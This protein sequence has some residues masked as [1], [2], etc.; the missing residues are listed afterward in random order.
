MAVPRVPNPVKKIAS[1]LSLVLGLCGPAVRAQVASIEAKGSQLA[2]PGQHVGDSDWFARMTSWR[3]DDAAATG[4]WIEAMRA[5]RRA[6]LG[7]MR[8]DGSQYLRPELGWTQRNFVQP[9]VMAEERYLYDPVAG[10]YTVDRLLDDLDRRYGGVDSVLLWPVYPNMGIDNRNQWD[11]ARDMPGGT[12]ALRAMVGDFHR[13]GVRVFFPTMPWD[14]GTRDVGIPNWEATARLM[15]EIGAD[16]VNGDTFDGIPRDYRIASDATGHPVALEPELSPRE[17]G[18]LAYNQ[19]S[20]AY[21]DY[22]FAPMVSKWKWLE[23]RHMVNVCDRWAKDHTDDLQAAFFNGVGFESWENIWGYWN[24]M[25]PRDAE[26]L[27]HMAAIYRGV[28]ELM[29]SADWTPHVPTLRYGV[30]ASS[31]PGPGHTLTTIVNRNDFDVGEEILEVGAAPGR[32][33]YDVWNGT[34]LRPRIDG[35]KAV[36]SLALGA[37]GFGAVL[38]VDPGCL[39][40]GLAALLAKVRAMSPRPLRSFSAEWAFLPQRLV[41]I[42]ATAPAGGAPPG[43]VRI[44][45]GDFTFRVGG[46]EVEGEDKV[47]I[48]VQYSWED[49][50]RRAHYHRLLMRPFFMDRFPVTNAEFRRFLDGAHY[51]PTDGHNFL[52][53]WQGG[54]PP[55][56]QEAAP[57]TWVS[58]EDARAYARWAGKR[59]PH[60]WEWQYA[61]QGTDGRTYPWGSTWDGS[62]VP[63]PWQ[64]RDLPPPAAVGSHP[65]GASPFGAEDMVGDVWQWTDE[66][67]DAHTRAAVLRGGS[68]YQPQ[69]SFWY[70]PNGYKLTEHGKYLLMAPSKDRAGTLGFRCVVDAR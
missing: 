52:K 5:W 48:D 70:F 14:K 31:F 23:P 51:Q 63:A 28:P 35:A 41:G 69:Q 29:V 67:E 10:R 12:P 33:Y 62:A 11:L 2:G 42:E 64:G 18:M 49:S 68:Y 3:R 65:R 26:A 24:Q 44:P 19:Q 50:P 53:D 1:T 27:R 39:P 30:F 17:D 61:A 66:Y 25:T 20:W 16:G 4:D 38:E 56:G 45:G 54:R 36:V 37:R 22:P 43:M 46:V 7:A 8:Y 13:R 40:G 21:W 9:Q 57:V 55:A 60:E 58:L 15:A 32:R 59:L 34:E 47:G 6:E